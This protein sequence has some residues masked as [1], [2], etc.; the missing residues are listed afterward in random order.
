MAGLSP[1]VLEQE[2]KKV[3]AAWVHACLLL[4][5][6]E[7]K[8]TPRISPARLHHSPQNR[9]HIVDGLPLPCVGRFPTDD[10]ERQYWPQLDKKAWWI[11]A[12]AIAEKDRGDGGGGSDIE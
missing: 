4:T 6:T 7:L 9:Q 2:I 8:K 12:H 11:L 3:Q 1:D 5:P 10:A